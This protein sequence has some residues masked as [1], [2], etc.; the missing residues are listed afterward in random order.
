MTVNNRGDCGE[1]IILQLS[2]PEVEKVRIP[3][4]GLASLNKPEPRTLSR[5]EGE[6]M[7]LFYYL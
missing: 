4:L 6:S 7:E 5:S 1:K 3:A 2:V